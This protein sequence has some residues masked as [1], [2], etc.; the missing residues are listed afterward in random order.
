MKNVHVDTR[1][2]AFPPTDFSKLCRLMPVKAA[3][4]DRLQ[5]LVI[6]STAAN[7]MLE[8]VDC[9]WL[10]SEGFVIAQA[11]WCWNEVER[12]GNAIQIVSEVNLVDTKRWIALRFVQQFYTS[13][14]SLDLFEPWMDDIHGHFHTC[15][16]E[17][18]R[19]RNWTF[20]P[21]IEF[22]NHVE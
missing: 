22:I 15:L 9:T 19:I 1:R 10:Y 18:G 14:S 21:R 13:T 6:G 8:N 2:A 17:N 7:S 12:G 3:S 4:A 20:N 5:Q 11:C 16:I